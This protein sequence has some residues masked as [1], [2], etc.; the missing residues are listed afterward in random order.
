M[1]EATWDVANTD[2]GSVNCRRVAILLSTDG[3]MT[4]D[5]LLA[6]DTA[7]NGSAMVTVPNLDT[8][9]ARLKVGASANLFFDINNA[10]FTIEM[11]AAVCPTEFEFWLANM[12]TGGFLDSNGNG[13]VD[14]ADLISCLP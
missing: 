4:F 1:L 5:Q 6:D 12:A 2:K 9:T 8:T 13:F 3:G 14:V 11:V 7:N 10:N